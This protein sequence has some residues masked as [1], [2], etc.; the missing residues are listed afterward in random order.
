MEELGIDMVEQ[1]FDELMLQYGITFS[2]VDIKSLTIDTV[3]TS[4]NNGRYGYIRPFYELW[5]DKHQKP[6]AGHYY[7][8]R[9]IGLKA[10]LEWKNW[11]N[12]KIKRDSAIASRK[13]QKRVRKTKQLGNKDGRKGSV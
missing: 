5:D 3:M 8:G 7:K 2:E 6:L 1:E 12:E 9:M 11:K 4:V 13:V 10:L